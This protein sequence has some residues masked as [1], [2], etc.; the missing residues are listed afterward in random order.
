MMENGEIITCTEE[1]STPGKMA[2]CMRATTKMIENMAMEYT[3][4][5]TENNMKAGGKTASNTEK[6]FIEKT[7]V[8]DAVSGKMV[9]E[10][11]G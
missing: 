3:P 7:V 1:E 5:T 4:G 11:N 6:E 8:T 10:L 2:G 9:K